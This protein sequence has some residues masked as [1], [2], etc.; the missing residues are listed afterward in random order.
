[1]LGLARLP[2]SSATIAQQLRGHHGR[3]R[4]AAAGRAPVARAWSNDLVSS[5]AP[6]RPGQVTAAG[7]VVLLGGIFVV[8]SAF[9][10][11]GALR[12][13]ET[14]EA[15][16]E[17]LA[18]PPGD[19]LGL[20]VEGVL[21]LM[22]ASALVAGGCAAAMAVLGF[23]VLRRHKPARLAVSVLAV[24]LAVTGMVLGGLLSFV[25]AAAV[26]LLWMPPARD[27]FDGRT[28]R[29]QPPSH[30][31]PGRRRGDHPGDHPGDQPGDQPDDAA[32]HV[33]PGRDREPAE[34][35]GAH[36]PDAH[37]SGEEAREQHD[38]PRSYEGFGTSTGRVQE[39]VRPE[40][41]SPDQPQHP[42][43]AAYPQPGR[44]T[45]WQQG[46]WP[47]AAQQPARRPAAVALACILTWVMTGLV[48]VLT[49][50]SLLV[51]TAS[52][53]FL[54]DE[55]ARQNPDLEEQGVTR[56]VLLGSTY[57]VG[58]LVVAWC[59]AAAVFAAFAFRGAGWARVAL[60]VS[61]VVAA[62]LSM[63]TSVGAPPM[64][65]PMLAATVVAAS[66]LRRESREF[67]DSHA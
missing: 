48:G 14:R 21:R 4:G 60:L 51:L 27:W 34:H 35:S 65:V 7:W 57:V 28:P 67:F 59:A 1:L 63:V 53:D 8:L 5:D 37:G 23:F 26:V 2:A 30:R 20:G 6:A 25:I 45:S 19:G 62:L 49:G 66:L 32:E 42:G 39:L 55:V 56:S 11:I 9:E 3:H 16:E 13:L 36:G 64:L 31:G 52:P 38:R 47:D 54:L 22:H 50:L 41:A 44:P 61:A 12:S 17:F 18:E 46:G 24:P 40:Q 15:V 33:A 58:A 43:P 29:Q 10:S